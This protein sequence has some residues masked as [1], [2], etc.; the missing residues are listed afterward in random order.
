ML[1]ELLREQWPKRFKP[2]SRR[3][4]HKIPPPRSGNAIHAGIAST[5][6]DGSN[7]NCLQFDDFVV[8]L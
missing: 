6:N 5:S 7:P 2:L 4:D 8:R 3:R 1:A